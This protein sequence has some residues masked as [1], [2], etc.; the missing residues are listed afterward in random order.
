MIVKSFEDSL[1]LEYKSW[2]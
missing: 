2:R 1:R